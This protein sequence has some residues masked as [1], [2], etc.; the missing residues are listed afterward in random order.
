MVTL[1]QSTPFA[2]ISPETSVRA[3]KMAVRKWNLE[4]LTLLMGQRFLNSHQKRTSR[5]LDAENEAVQRKML[6]ADLGAK[7]EEMGDHII[8]GDNTHPTPIVINQQPQQSSGTLG[9]VLAGAA[10]SAGILGI[11]AAGIIGYGVSQWAAQKTE[12][13]PVET[14]D[15]SLDI[16]LGRFEDLLHASDVIE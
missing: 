3:Q 12:Q 6:G 13:K 9:K 5:Q 4:A 7:V 10:L 16:G 14:E 8:L 1:E 2:G 15:T 11:P